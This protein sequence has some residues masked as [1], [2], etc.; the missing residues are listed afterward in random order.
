MY[1]GGEPP[2]SSRIEIGAYTYILLYACIINHNRLLLQTSH[3][4]NGARAARND[5]IIHSC[6]HTL[7]AQGLAHIF[8]SFSIPCRFL[9][10]ISADDKQIFSHNFSQKYV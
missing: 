7:V 9:S 4:T 2:K 5:S 1:R 6:T 8:L 3:Q 10:C